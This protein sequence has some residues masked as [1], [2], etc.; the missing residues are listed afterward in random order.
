MVGDCGPTLRISCLSWGVLHAP[1]TS[2]ISA[3]L[4]SR[5]PTCQLPHA[6]CRAGF[7][8]CRERVTVRCDRCVSISASQVSRISPHATNRVNSRG[9]PVNRQ[10]KAKFGSR[11]NSSLVWRDVTHCRLVDVVTLATLGWACAAACQIVSPSHRTETDIS[12]TQHWHHWQSECI[13]WVL[14]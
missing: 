13:H 3:R 8:D 2:Y 14:H 6:S 7:R 5:R 4:A 1:M 10:A 11:K 9:S 12:H